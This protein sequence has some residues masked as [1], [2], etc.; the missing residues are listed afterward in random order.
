MAARNESK[1]PDADG[2]IMKDGRNCVSEADGNRP[3]GAPDPCHGQPSAIAL[4]MFDGVHIGHQALVRRAVEIAKSHGW[5]SVVYTFENHPRSVVGMAPTL[6]M[7]ADARRE[8]LLKLGADCVDMVKFT[9]SFG[10]KSPRAFI[11][12]LSSR[13]DVRAVVAGV[14]FKFGHRGSGNIETLRALGAEM[15]FEVFEMPVVLLDGEKVSSTR[16]RAALQSGNDALA[17]RM[18]GR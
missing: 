3:K 8:A 16:I 18:L 9:K 14:D 6:L 2:L 5:R 4:G 11:K 12:Y 1:K 10:E 7:D 17:T 15:G 13:Y